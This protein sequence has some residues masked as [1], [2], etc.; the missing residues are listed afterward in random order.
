MHAFVKGPANKP[1][2]KFFGQP[3]H[4]LRI[5]WSDTPRT[6]QDQADLWVG[7]EDVNEYRRPFEQASMWLGGTHVNA[8]PRM[9]ENGLM[10]NYSIQVEVQQD[11]CA[12]RW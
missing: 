10:L 7:F 2:A 3:P 8:E 11:V 9:K 5:A 6:T 1:T 12:L 4:G